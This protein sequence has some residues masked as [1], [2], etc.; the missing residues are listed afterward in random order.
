MNEKNA[1]PESKLA[2]LPAVVPKEVTLRPMPAVLQLWPVTLV[3]LVFGIM[4]SFPRFEIGKESSGNAALGMIFT[5]LFFAN[6]LS[7]FVRFT[8]KRTIILSI[9]VICLLILAV[10]FWDRLRSFFVGIGPGMDNRFYFVWFGILA[11][12]SLLALLNAQF[13]YWVVRTDEIVHHPGLFGK[14]IRYAA[15]HLR[16]E[17]EIPDV[18]SYI[19]LRSGRLVVFTSSE[20]KPIF[21]ENV[22]CINRIEKR[23]IAM[24]GAKSD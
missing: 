8:N 2:P 9:F 19:L 1:Q 7:L 4:A 16:I 6:M 21:L 3:A 17:K 11:I 10:P 13:E 24:G 23:L 5:L 18:L 14:S 15:P 20:G 22:V 12:I